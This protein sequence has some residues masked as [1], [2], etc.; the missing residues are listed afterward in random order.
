MRDS[1]AAEIVDQR[2]VGD[3]DQPMV[4]EVASRLRELLDRGRLARM[5]EAAGSLARPRS[6]DDIVDLVESLRDGA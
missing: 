3:V 6:T 1:G 4:A 5:A 2:M